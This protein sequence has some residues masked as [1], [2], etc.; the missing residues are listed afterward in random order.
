M[1]PRERAW[2]V[3]ARAAF[4]LVCVATWP[5]VA[6]APTRRCARRAARLG[7]RVWLRVT[8]LRLRACGVVDLAC[9]RRPCV[10]VANHASK[11][12]VVVLLAVLPADFA[13][14]AKD[15]LEKVWWLRRPLRRVGTL[16][17]HRHGERVGPPASEQA[18][19]RLHARQPAVLPRGYRR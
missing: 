15:E 16:F 4:T 1:S 18:L 6:L 8:G 7:A 2:S 10:L 9:V 19:T 12:D 3:W 13:F 17:V 5:L 11:L 14:V